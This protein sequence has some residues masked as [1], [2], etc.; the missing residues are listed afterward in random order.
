[1]QEKQSSL[2]KFAITLAKESARILLKVQNK[3]K[4]VQYKGTGGDF[5]LNADIASEQHVMKRIRQKYPHHDIL[6][7]ETGHHHK[8][9]DYLWIIDPLEGTLNYAHHLPIWAVNI[10]LFYKMKPYLGAI[11]APETKE[12]FYASKGKG[13][14]LN[15]KR[16]H[17]NKDT[18]LMKSFFC[19]SVKQLCNVQISGH[20]LRALGCGGV[21]LAYVACGRFGARIL[22]HGNDPYGYGAGSIIVLEAGGKL[23]DC[24]GKQWNL[25]SDG[26]IAS[27]GKIH[28]KLLNLTNNT[29]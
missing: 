19:G 9:S 24:E 25:R 6:T 4:I 21:E 23:T 7:E 8:D 5:A 12:L 13:A 28:E 17:V 16:I 3:A 11:Y 29:S 14:Y 1:M 22:R 2:L 10:G 27:N 18:N 15:G 20:L 26:A